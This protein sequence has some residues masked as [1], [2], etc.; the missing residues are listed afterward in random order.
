MK[1][2]NEIDNEINLTSKGKRPIPLLEDKYIKFPLI[3]EDCEINFIEEYRQLLLS[4]K[5]LEINDLYKDLLKIEVNIKEKYGLIRF[6]S[7]KQKREGN[8]YYR[9][10]L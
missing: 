10:S 3:S 7:I 4:K 6:L 2:L 1:E 9:F 8:L 5:N